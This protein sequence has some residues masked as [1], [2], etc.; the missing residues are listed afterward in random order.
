MKR[1]VD[2]ELV[3]D[4][5]LN[6]IV[7][8]SNLIF[9][10]AAARDAFLT[11]DLAPVPGMTVYLVTPD[12]LGGFQKRIRAGG[13]DYW[14][15]LPGSP[16]VGVTTPTSVTTMPTGAATQ[17]V[18]MTTVRAR[19]VNTMWA[20]NRFTPT[21]PGWYQLDAIIYY[22]S[23][24]GDGYRAA[25]L[26]LNGASTATAIPGSWCQIYPAVAGQVSVHTRTV[27][28]YF[29]GV[30]GSYVTLMGMHNSTSTVQTGGTA[31][32][33]FNVFTAK[34]LGM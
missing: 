23:A 5:D 34:Y 9:A 28:Q 20:N 25:W 13:T 7:S 32:T 22:Y 21:L 6:E 10:T 27:L 16:V 26:S 18:A 30:D 33:G 14:A 24:A 12:A 4:T 11:G 19:N 31:W 2:G 8:Q 29:D 17:I 15:P 1:W 3:Y